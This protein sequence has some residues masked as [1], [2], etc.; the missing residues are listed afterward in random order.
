MW[1]RGKIEQWLLL[2]EDVCVTR[3]EVA[4]SVNGDVPSRGC[5]YMCLDRG[6]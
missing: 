5:A 2:H 6:R 4:Y 1:R 3:E